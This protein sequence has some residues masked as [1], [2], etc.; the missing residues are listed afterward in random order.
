MPRLESHHAVGSDHVYAIRK[1]AIA[2]RHR[3]VDLVNY[4]RDGNLQIRRA[5]F[6]DRFSLFIGRMLVDLNSIRFIVRGH[7]AFERMGF[8]YIYKTEF[9]LILV[10]LVPIFG[11]TD[12]VSERSSGITPEHKDDRLFPR[13]R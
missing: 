1:T 4:C 12:T 9:C 13:F 8:F 11:V 10:L 7:P 2:D 6:R 3:V 5:H